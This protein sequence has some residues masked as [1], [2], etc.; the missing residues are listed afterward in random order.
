MASRTQAP[1]ICR[2]PADQAVDLPMRKE[3]QRLKETTSRSPYLARAVAIVLLLALFAA[4]FVAGAGAD[5]ALLL[6]GSVAHEPPGVAATFSIFWETWS[7]VQQ[8]Y[9]D[10]SAVEPTNMTRGAV[11]GLLASLGDQGHTRFLTPEELAQEREELAGRLEG[12]GAQVGI[13]DERPTIVAPIPG[14]PAQ[15]AGLRSGDIIIRVDGKEVAGMTLDEIVR[16]VRGRPGTS[17]TLTVLHR[18]DANPTDITVV[19]AAVQVPAITW[20]VLPGTNVTHILIS[21]FGERCTEQ[22]VE[23][24]GTSRSSGGRAI[25]LDLRNNPGGIRDEAVGVASQFLKEGNVLLEEDAEGNVQPF[26]VKPGGVAIDTPLV[27]LVNEGS[28]SSSEVVAGA[29][30]DYRRARLVG[31]TTFG[32]GTVLTPF[33]LSDGSAILLGTSQWKTPLGRQIWKRGIVPDVQVPLKDD[34]VPLLPQETASLTLDQLRASSDTQLVRALQ[35]LSIALPAHRP[36]NQP[37]ARF[38]TANLRWS[39]K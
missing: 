14:S 30:Q 28:A 24:I 17:V 8:H 27:V 18:G 3:T 6:P 33:G 4:G 21:E 9:V 2:G 7:L 35:E 34:A 11:R 5:R 22:L 13:R 20:A 31:T 12:I 25:I 26:P 29:I 39:D 1:P 10:R 19:R 36:T 37:I 32:T 15:Q 38:A 23:A 16:M